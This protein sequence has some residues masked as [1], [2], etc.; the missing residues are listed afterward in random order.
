MQT[1]RLM[2]RCISVV[3]LVTLAMTPIAVAAPAEIT[4]LTPAAAIAGGADFTLTISG[5]YF[6]STAV[7]M[8]NNT[9][10]TTT[11]ESATE[12]TA[13][14]PASLIATAGSASVSVSTDR[15]SSA[16]E[17]FFISAPAVSGQSPSPSVARGFTLAV[18]SSATAP[19]VIGAI[20]APSAAS[21]VTAN[22]VSPPP[23]ITGMSPSSV[24]A[25]GAAFTLTVSGTN[26]ISTAVVMWNNTALT[27]TYVS[28]T[29]LKA[30]VPASLIVSYSTVSITVTTSGGVSPSAIFTI[31]PPP[32]IISD[33]QPARLYVGNS[34]FVLT[35]DGSYFT[36]ST[37]VLWGNTPLVMSY[38]FS[39]CIM[40]AVPA[41][42]VATAGTASV[43]VTTAGGTS[44]VTTFTIDPLPQTISSLSP[45]SVPAGSAAFTLTINGNNF[46]PDM[47]V[48]W[49]NIPLGDLSFS[50]T[51]ITVSISAKMVASAGIISINVI[52]S[53]GVLAQPLNLTITPAPPV[54]TSLNPS[55]LTAG[56]AGFMM[57]VYG[58][59]F[60]Q[61]SVCTWG[62][63]VL[64]TI[65]VGPTQLTVSVPASL[66]E[67]AGTGSI[68]VTTA[69]GT[70]SPI[71]FTINQALPAISG[72]NPGVATAGGTAF[73]IT[74]IGAYYT[75]TSVAKWGST[76]LTTTYVNTTML[77]A[78]VPA[79]LI[80]AV[81]TTRITVTTATGTSPPA[82]FTTF[83]APKITTTTLPSGTVGI[84][85]SGPISVTGG[86]P[87]YI[88]TVTGLP[89]SFSH[90]NNS[91]STLTIT[92]TPVSSGVISFQVSAQ[93]M[94]GAVAGPVTFTINV[95]AGPSGANNTSL[96]GS[97]VCLMQGAIDYDQT[98]WASLASF[99]ADGEGHFTNG[100]FDTNS[101]E[102]GSASG[103]LTGSYQIGS[104]NSGLASIRTVLTD[105]AAG[106]QTVQW[107][108]ALYGTQTPAQHFRMM[109]TDDLGELP[110][111]QQGTAECQLASTSA[112]A[113][114]TIS[115][116]SFVF[117][118]DGEDNNG[119]LKAAVGRFSAAAGHSVSGYIESALGGSATVQSNAFTGSY[120]APDPATG[121]FT[122]AL[123]GNNKLSGFTIYIIDASHMFILDNTWNEGEQAGNLLAQQQSTYSGS[124]VS[125]PLVFY[126]RGAQFNASGNTPSGYY[127]NLFQGTG[128]GAA[129]ITFNQSYANAEGVY[130]AGKPAGGSTALTFDA[131]NPGRVT[132]TSSSGTTYLYLFNANS[133]VEMSVSASGSL[134]T[135]WLEPQTQ[136]TFTNAALSGNYLY[137]AVHPFNPSS[138]GSVGVYSLTGSGALNASLTTAGENILTWEQAISASY[139]WDKTAPGTGSFLLAN[140]TQG[141][142]GCA[143]ISASKFAC[144]SQTDASPSVQL[145]EQ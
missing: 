127:S 4:G 7:V 75:P 91:D 102:I 92:G 106:I 96:N 145:I 83:P 29:T 34:D 116:S 5:T 129:R 81:G 12:L 144:I 61:N 74:I 28:T 8:W 57:T 130:T 139:A 21:A 78:A 58:K 16:S 38:S 42:L 56:S 36:P 100:I 44:A 115:G 110:S 45:I 63:N 79:S 6:T 24:V 141:G 113:V 86:V 140:N 125:G 50:S 135:G 52:D 31:N 70:S 101:Y 73:T 132:F 84:A 80:T 23:T 25:N 2:M 131:S 19:A 54:I 89:S 94:A 33:L 71:V 22:T 35:I 27:T 124:S 87:G 72:L 30:A 1:S 143:V 137:G 97:Y 93:D 142:A 95:V 55:S 43:T 105:G 138:S 77:T 109:E 32:P 123:H 107:A 120:T 121:R 118:L 66:T 104:D 103:V 82:T 85:Y 99:Q 13:M 48:M 51:Q 17:S 64:D 60:T 15:E 119:T 9:A 47:T 98:R 114:S 37:V 20:A 68:T 26:F 41:R 11:Y 65:Y 76:S 18:N 90:T 134:D 10:L 111:G 67:F 136:S 39:H 122:I 14:V 3:F 128:N 117:G 126:L 49:E 88:W 112:F 53:H 133:A 46:T 59:A 69:V 40:A 108:L 62:N